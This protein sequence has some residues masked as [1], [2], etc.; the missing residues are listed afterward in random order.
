MKKKRDILPFLTVACTLALVGMT[1]ALILGG[2]EAAAFAPPLFES[3]AVQG[4][5]DV[6]EELGHSS[7]CTEEVDYSFS[8]CGNVRMD[9]AAAVVYFTDPPENRVWLRLCILDENDRTLGETGLLRPGEY[10]RAVT[11]DKPLAAGT[12]VKLKVMGCEPETY[13]S[14]GTIVMHTTVCGIWP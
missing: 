13:R 8:V 12:P 5:P 2:E 14:A 1:L 7:P 3:S 6:P 11:L 9:G 4:I 10:V